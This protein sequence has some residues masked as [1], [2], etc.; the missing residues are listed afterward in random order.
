[1]AEEFYESWSNWLA[2][3]FLEIFGVAEHESEMFPKIQNMWW[4]LKKLLNFLKIFEV[5]TLKIKEIIIKICE[6]WGIFLQSWKPSLTYK[7]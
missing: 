1:M 5:Y 4:F 7:E 6:I 2:I 3:Y